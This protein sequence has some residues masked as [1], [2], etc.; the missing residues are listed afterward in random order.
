MLE[1]CRNIRSRAER[2]PVLVNW[3][4]DRSTTSTVLPAPSGLRVGVHAH[5][6]LLSPSESGHFMCYLNRTFGV[7]ATLQMLHLD[8]K[9]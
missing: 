3:Q 6:L 2:L 9:E 7:L 1:R 8:F 4:V 5:G